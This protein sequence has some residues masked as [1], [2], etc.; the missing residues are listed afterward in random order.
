MSWLQVG[1]KF[2]PESSYFHEI[3]WLK[4]ILGMPL[5]VATRKV[6]LCPLSLLSQSHTEIDPNQS[7]RNI[8]LLELEIFYGS[9]ALHIYPLGNTKQARSLHNFYQNDL[10][11]LFYWF[12]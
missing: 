11:Q 4:Q 2:R 10:N 3:L 9:I 6:E 7:F 12:V 5:P 8:S 1:D